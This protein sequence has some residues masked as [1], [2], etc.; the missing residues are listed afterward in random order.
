MSVEEQAGL[1]AGKPAGQTA[2]KR[3]AAAVAAR[4]KPSC[5]AAMPAAKGK[6]GHVKT[7]PSKITDAKRGWKVEERIREH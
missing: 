3:P 4:K 2:K 5:G 6:W 7:K 1:V